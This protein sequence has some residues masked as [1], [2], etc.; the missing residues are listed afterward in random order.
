MGITVDIRGFGPLA[1]PPL[2]TGDYLRGIKK[3][4]E[5]AGCRRVIITRVPRTVSI[6]ERA[7]I[8]RQEVATKCNPNKSLNLLGH[9]MV[10]HL[11]DEPDLGAG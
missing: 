8:P 7:E 11:V 4:L 5:K 10:S 9:S 1:L 3:A 2:A 6:E